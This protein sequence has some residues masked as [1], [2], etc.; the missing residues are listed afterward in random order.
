MKSRDERRRMIDCRKSRGRGKARRRY[1]GLGK[2]MNVAGK[3]KRILRE[4]RG[5]FVSHAHETPTRSLHRPVH[6]PSIF[7]DSSFA[8][9]LS[10][11]WQAGGQIF[12]DSPNVALYFFFL[13]TDSTNIFSTYT[14]LILCLKQTLRKHNVCKAIRAVCLYLF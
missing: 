1:V 3:E 2:R 12:V 10:P 7:P 13:Q 6:I 14:E 9:I 5:N 8:F 4:K 11:R